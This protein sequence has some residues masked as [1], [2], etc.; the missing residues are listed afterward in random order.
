[1]AV[2]QVTIK[3]VEQ[4]RFKADSEQRQDG[5]GGG[6]GELAGRGSVGLSAIDKGTPCRRSSSMTCSTDCCQPWATPSS[7]AGVSPIKRSRAHTVYRI[8]VRTF[9]RFSSR[10]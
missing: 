5:R 8:P 1:M 6:V 10:P 4:G 7:E 9:F 2:Y 3:V